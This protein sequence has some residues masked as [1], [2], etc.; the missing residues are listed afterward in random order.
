MQGLLRAGILIGSLGVLDDVAVTQAFTVGELAAANRGLG[1]RQLYRAATRVGRAHIASVV[2]P[3]VLAYAGASLPI[4]LLLAASNQPVGE[5]LT[6]QFI[7]QEIVRAAVGTMGLV[8]AVPI[9][10]TLAAFAASRPAHRTPT[11]SSS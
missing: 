6:N 9:T 11:A 8:A 10:T 1:F 5:V 4:L 3:I 2:N 7:A